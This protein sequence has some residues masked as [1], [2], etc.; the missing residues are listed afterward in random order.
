MDRTLQIAKDAKKLTDIKMFI[1][2]KINEFEELEK[3]LAHDGDI[4]TG[5]DLGEYDNVKKIWRI[6]NG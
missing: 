4:L 5:Y 2:D 6:I 1:F 3:R